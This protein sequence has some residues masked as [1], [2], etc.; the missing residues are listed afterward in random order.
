MVR[1]FT[2][3]ER[4]TRLRALL[5]GSLFAAF[6][7]GA[8]AP[9]AGASGESPV[10]RFRD[11]NYKYSVKMFEG[12][13]QVPLETKSSGGFED[14]LS[15][16]AASKFTQKGA[17]ERGLRNSLIEFYR[18]AKD[19]TGETT[20]SDAPDPL[21]KFRREAA[22]KTMAGLLAKAMGR[23]GF[24]VTLDPSVAK[25]IKSRDDVPGSYWVIDRTTK[26]KGRD[27]GES[28]YLVAASWKKDEVEIGMWAVCE[29]PLKKKLEGG[30]KAV[31]DS[32]T[33]YD[34]KAE[35]VV[36]K[37]VLEGLRISAKKRR[38]IEKGLVK[39]WDVIVSPKKNYIVLY[40]TKNTRNNALAKIIAER[41]EKIRE[42]VYE[43][44]FVPAAPVEAV[45]LVR[46]CGDSTEYHAYGGPGGSAGYWSDDTEELVFYDMSPKKEPDDDTLAV[47]YHEAFHQFIYYSVGN[48]APHSWFNEGHGDYYAGSK[49]G[50]GQF[51]IHPFPWR[52]PII[53]EAI[54][55]G[56]I[57]CEAVKGEDG[58]IERYQVDDGAGG[59]VPLSALVRMSQRDYYSYA[60]VCYAEG[61]SLVYFL[62]E[63]VPKNDKW[64]AKWGKILE[65]YFKTLKAEVNRDRPLAPPV[66]KP[67]DPAPPEE[68]GM[69]EPSMGDTPPPDATPPTPP[70]MDGGPTEPPPD[71]GGE[72]AIAR[73]FSRYE[74]SGRALRSAVDAAFKG[75]DFAELE[76]AW[77]A[78]ILK[79]GS[80]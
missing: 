19:M 45:C 11:R 33:W 75:I 60:N 59:Y 79:V 49:Y 63:I 31:A 14:A 8:A 12:W 15:T 35:D 72:P 25:A 66:V 10:N 74:S 6:A 61:W 62:R 5:L 40:N 42:Q 27:N 47:L 44:Q 7:F 20:P 34:D 32:F 52:V 73:F 70:G 9:D 38:E 29:G 30:F 50:G 71:G 65:T 64:N 16:Y 54:R 57:A 22:P 28:N 77:K 2:F 51:K 76:T 26:T 18:I 48:V 68:P 46:V 24:E 58:E 1:S 55:K 17:Q 3:A 41:I 23:Y 4:P 56:V 67:E 69:D 39:G 78:A 80:K 43:V 36:S 13:D 21:A 53:K 37:P